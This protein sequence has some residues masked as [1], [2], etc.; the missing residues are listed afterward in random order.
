MLTTPYPATIFIDS[1]NIVHISP[2][3]GNI[4]SFE[5]H[6][7]DIVDKNGDAY[8]D[9]NDLISHVGD[10]FADALVRGG[11]PR[12]IYKATEKTEIADVDEH[13]LFNS[14]YSGVGRIIPSNS[15]RVGSVIYVK[16]NGLFTTLTGGSSTNKILLGDTQLETSSVTYLNNRTNYYIENEIIATVRSVGVNGSIIYQGRDLVQSSDTQYT[17]AMLPRKTLVPITIDTTVDNL[18]DMTFKWNTLGGSLVVS[19]AIIQIL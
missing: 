9:Y 4:Q 11:C 19:N 7:S 15:L 8:A 14:S 1:D 10:F 16:M 3:T 18:F 6:I 5:C 2:L 12:T 17:L 13:S